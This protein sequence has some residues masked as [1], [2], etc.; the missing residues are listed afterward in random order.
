MTGADVILVCD[1]DGSLIRTDLLF[2]T[3]WSAFSARW[4]APLPATLALLRGRAA[5]K[6]HLA[7]RGDIDVSRLPY[8]EEVLAE[9]RAWRASGGRTALVTAADQA[10]ADRIALHLGLFDEVHGSDGLVNLKGTAKAQML[11]TRFGRGGYDYIGDSRSD[12]KVWQGARR[13]ISVDAPEALQRGAE[14]LCDMRHFGR[15][16][17]TFRPLMKA[18]R[19]HQWAKNAL[20]F[21]P[22]LAGH[23]FGADLLVRVLFAFIAFSLVASSVYVLNDLLDLEADRAHPRKR[24]RPF[25]SGALPLSYGTWLAPCLLLGGVGIAAMLGPVFLAVMA[26]YYLTTTLYSLRLKR[27]PVVDICTLAALYALRIVAGAAAVPIP[28]SVWMLAFSIFFFF[29]LAAVKR[30]AELVDGLATGREAKGR[31]YQVDDLPLVSMM[32]VAAGYVSIMVLAL[33]VNSPEVR[34]LY[35]RPEWLWG[36]CAVL[37]YWI[38]RMVFITHRGQMHDDPVV[39]AARDKVSYLVFLSMLGFIAAG[40]LL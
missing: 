25:A 18:L 26:V 22:A 19:P 6:A 11:E 35:E 20:V 24:N 23:A 4:T 21:L 12:L 13:G 8:N 15:P 17:G 40:T 37:L 34:I 30:Q 27:L 29:S 5:L 38:S 31:G 10:L 39:F 36:I 33:Y 3:F 32:A 9:L 7:G 14:A 2:E 1:L 16:P 28:L